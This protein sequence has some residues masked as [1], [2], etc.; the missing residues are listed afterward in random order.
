MV[1]A[2]AAGM[3]RRAADRLDKRFEVGFAQLPGVERRHAPVLAVGE[4]V[5]GR[6]AHPHACREEVLP[7]PCVAAVGCEADRH[8]GDEA[9]LLR[10]SCELAVEVELQ[11]LVEGHAA[12]QRPAYR[13][14]PFAAGVLELRRPAPPCRPKAFGDGAEGRVV[15]E[16]PALPADPRLHAGGIG[17]DFEDGRERARLEVENSVVVDES[18][19]VE[20]QRLISYGLQLCRAE[21]CAGHL[22]DTQV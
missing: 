14:D 4:E 11:P 8:V 3:F 5:V 2:Q 19:G 18:L 16:R 17:R 9:D 10:R 6:R 1:E 21:L 20:G 15:L 13:R 12:G 22:V 7:A